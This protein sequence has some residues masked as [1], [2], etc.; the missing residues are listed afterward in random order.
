[1]FL[2]VWTTIVGAVGSVLLLMGALLLWLAYAAHLS[3]KWIAF[4][5]IG[6]GAVL[7]MAS[8]VASRQSSRRKQEM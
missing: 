8:I 5:M 6:V 1:M 7:L 4:L 2:F 3:D